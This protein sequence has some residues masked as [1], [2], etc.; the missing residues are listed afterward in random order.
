M[1]FQNIITISLIPI[2]LG[3]FSIMDNIKHLEYD[4]KKS[5][6]YTQE[7]SD[8]LTQKYAI[9]YADTA[10]MGTSKYYQKIKSETKWIINNQILT[11]GSRPIKVIPNPHKIDTILFRQN[12]E[13]DFDTIICNIANPYSYKFVFNGC[14]GGFNVSSD[15][16]KNR[17]SLRLKLNTPKNEKYLGILGSSGKLLTQQDTIKDFCKSA[18]TPNVFPVQLLKISN[19][20]NDDCEELMCLIE[21]GLL[22]YGDNFNYQISKEILNFLFMPLNN[23]PLEIFYDAKQQKIKIQ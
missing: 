17:P 7:Y 1:K 22:D 3:Y 21:D 20:E 8:N 18:L 4:V 16:I 19:C 13:R 23:E 12:N 15:S 9:F 2:L 14:C 10:Y 11:Y 5:K 6:K